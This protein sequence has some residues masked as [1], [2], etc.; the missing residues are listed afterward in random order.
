MPYLSA[1]GDEVATDFKDQVAFLVK[2]NIK[3]IEIR[4]VNGKNIMDLS[5]SEIAETKQIL[6]DHGIGVSAIG[7]P[8]GKS[9]IDEPLEA[10]IEKMKHA[11]HLA[12]S[13][14]TE[15]IRVFSYYAPEGKNIDDYGDA[16]IERLGKLAEL[17]ENTALSMAHENETH[18]FG[19]SAENCAKL[20]QALPADSF[21][22]AYDPANFIWGDLIEKPM[23]QSWPLVE[24]Y[25]KHVH[26]KDWSLGAESG[27]MPGEG[28]GQFK[29]LF[30][31]L[32]ELN[33]TGFLTMEPHLSEAGQFGGATDPVLYSKAI[34]AVRDLAAETQL[35]LF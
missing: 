33:Y 22:M 16:V 32:G 3:F 34:Q 2:E 8:I 27:S 26:I 18:I 12:E 28:H 14:A 10:E 6:A 4:F 9:I 7:S 1:F 20:A 13:F 24:P 5:P 11:I 15:R 25:V 17:V 35:E 21:H 23:Q 19:H 31:R 30:V 29:E